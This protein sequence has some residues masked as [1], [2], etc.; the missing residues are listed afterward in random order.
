MW[1]NYFKNNKTLMYVAYNVVPEQSMLTNS[2]EYQTASLTTY[3]LKIHC[4]LEHA[5]EPVDIQLDSDKF[6][7]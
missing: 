6:A 2:F 3:I 4:E 1:F 5:V 7:C